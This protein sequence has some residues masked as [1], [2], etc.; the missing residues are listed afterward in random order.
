[1]VSTPTKNR[2]GGPYQGFLNDECVTLAEV[3]DDAG[4][5]TGAFVGAFVLD[6]RWGLDQGFERY[7]ERPK[8][9]AAAVEQVGRADTGMALGLAS[10]M[11][12]KRLFWRPARGD[13]IDGPTDGPNGCAH[14][15]VP[16]SAPSNCPAPP[17]AMTT[18]LPVTESRVN[19]GMIQQCW[20][21][22]L[23]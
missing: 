21:G 15:R 12:L 23:P 17:F 1:M 11:A 14:Y 7:D 8:G 3:L 19:V 2:P 6:G 5:A 16:P 18:T 20:S 10:A 22:S 4:Y 9:I 13:A